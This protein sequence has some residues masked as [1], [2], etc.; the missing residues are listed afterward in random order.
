M[1]NA[2]NN[3]REQGNQQSQD[4]SADLGT[5]ATSGP[6]SWNDQTQVVNAQDQNQGVNTGDPE[7]KEN[8]TGRT[9]EPTPRDL[10]ISGESNSNVSEESTGGAEIETPHK[11]E[12]DDEISTERKIPKM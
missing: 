2:N 3:S 6:N 9:D 11:I 1:Q 10:N 7:Y 4:F 8:V 5:Q 12:G